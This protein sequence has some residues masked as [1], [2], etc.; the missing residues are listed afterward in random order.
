MTQRVAQ[1]RDLLTVS[2][3]CNADREVC[4][5]LVQSLAELAPEH[6]YC[7]NPEPKPIKVF[8]INLEE[9]PGG[10]A[11]L[12]WQQDKKGEFVETNHRAPTDV[13]R[14]LIA[15]SPSLLSALRNSA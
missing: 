7:I 5:A 8:Q 1:Q 2:V 3:I 6:Q 12:I 13:S 14:D 9:K 11:R 15:A 4:R 10:F